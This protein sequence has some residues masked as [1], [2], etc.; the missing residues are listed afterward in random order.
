MT[1]LPDGVHQLSPES[2]EALR[3][4]AEKAA[5]IEK[6][7]TRNNFENGFFSNLDRSKAKIIKRGS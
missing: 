7:H 3:R 4:A 5:A 2:I 1:K 6:R